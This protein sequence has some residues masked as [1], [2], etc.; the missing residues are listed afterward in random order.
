MI[1][2]GIPPT[3]GRNTEQDKGTEA[4][5]TLRKNDLIDIDITGMTAQ[6]AGVGHW[7]GMAV[8]TPL[9]APGDRAR[10]RVVKA[11]KSYA[12]GRLEE[13]LSPSP[14][15]VEPDCPCFA[16]CG[17]CCYRHIRYEAELNIKEAR[18]R[19]A[20]ERIGGFSGLPM[21][22]ILGGPSRG[23]DRNKALPPL[24]VEKDGSPS[25]GF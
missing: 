12:F 20:L 25:K 2:P 22:P 18:G 9:T 14:D 24:G 6:G 11:A 15:R 4:M 5:T 23:G 16:Q 13:L 17:G 21:R 3:A 10:V 7:E 1:A 19:D 8:F